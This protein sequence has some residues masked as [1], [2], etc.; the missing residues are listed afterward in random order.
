MAL[1][2][3]KKIDG[4]SEFA[5]WKI[6]E[7]ADELYAQ[8]Q[9]RDHEKKIIESLN[10]G[11]R[12]LHW[13]STRVLLRKLLKTS[14]YIDCLADEN[15]KP[16]LPYSP[17]FISFSHS[18]DYAAVMISKDKEVGID[19]E[20]IKNKIE[21]VANK[22]LKEEEL[23][24]IEAEHRIEQLYVCWC[25]KEAIYKF[26]GKKNVS[27]KDHITLKPFK[28]QTMGTF[29]ASLESEEDCK[30]F[31]VFY[32]KFDNYMIGYVA[33]CITS[34][35]EHSSSLVPTLNEPTYVLK[36]AHENRPEATTKYE[37]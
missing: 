19:I 17:Y 23:S 16:Y 30:V 25:A 12:N 4:N 21:R 34:N 36:C 28:Y 27:F 22:F 29:D 6:E 33:G 37:K 31:D 26:Q 8:L 32:E 10:N 9:L 13:L 1:A 20:I 18:F 14:E 35:V 3:H 7:S 5:L 11:K 24:F 2:Y 15:G